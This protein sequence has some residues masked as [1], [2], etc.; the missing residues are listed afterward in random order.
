M[1]KKL[2]L[3]ILLII[4]III[5]FFLVSPRLIISKDIDL[6]NVSLNS[7][8]EFGITITNLSRKSFEVAKIYT[9]CGCTKT[10]GRISFN[11]KRGETVNAVFEFDP[12]SMHQKG[13]S[14]NHEIY[15][16]VTNPI[17]KE[18]KVKITGKVI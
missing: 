12:S 9:S 16:L 13:D 7:K 17:E 15:F 2:T 4:L 8:K 5:S 14:I 10:I 3:V 6:G 11:I 18:Y 1:K